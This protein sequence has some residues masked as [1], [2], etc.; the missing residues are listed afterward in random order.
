[1]IRLPRANCLKN[2]QLSLL[3]AK[4]RKIGLLCWKSLRL[5]ARSVCQSIRYTCCFCQPI[6]PS[7]RREKKCYPTSYDVNCTFCQQKK[8]E[9]LSLLFLLKTHYQKL[10]QCKYFFYYCSL[11]YC[12]ISMVSIFKIV[13]P[14]NK[15]EIILR[16]FQWIKRV[17]FS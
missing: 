9:K 12:Q 4:N 13:L 1:M 3:I 7:Y 2:L 8:N 14:K 15:S 10:C 6:Y 17:M 16:I 5:D 11:C